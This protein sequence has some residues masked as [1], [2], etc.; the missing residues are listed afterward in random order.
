M[1]VTHADLALYLGTEV[2]EAR[3]TFLIAMAVSLVSEIIAD[4][5][6]TAR[7]VVLSAVA[8][9]YTNPTGVTTEMVGPYQ[10]TRP[11]AG[12]YLTK[13]ERA[14]LRRLAGRSG[15]FSVDLLPPGY[16]GDATTIAEEF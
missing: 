8:R 13:P 10:A 2:D 4:P 16:P 7:A 11:S 5:P 9:A 15:A 1:D 12:V 6:D 14:S 3:A